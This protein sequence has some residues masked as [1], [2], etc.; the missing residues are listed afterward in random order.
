MRIFKSENSLLV[1]LL[2]ETTTLKEVVANTED[3]A[4][5]KHVPEV[6]L[7]GNVVKVQV[8]S[9]LHPMIDVH[10]IEVIAVETTKGF[11]IKYLN[12]GEL[13][14]AEFALHNEEFKAAYAYCNLHG[15]WKNK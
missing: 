1:N 3:A 13:P 10:Y 14:V 2:G 4:K 5:E 7:D 8:G 9:V 12:P 6:S 11:Q 15:L